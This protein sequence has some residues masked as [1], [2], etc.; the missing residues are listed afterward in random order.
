MRA[1]PTQGSARG[2]CEYLRGGC[3]PDGSRTPLQPGA[4][5]P[6]GTE[7]GSGMLLV[8]SLSRAEPSPQGA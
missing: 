6:Q 7:A 3:D 1:L 4:S 2:A 5:L 8:T